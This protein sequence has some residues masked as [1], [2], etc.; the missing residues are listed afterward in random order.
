VAAAEGTP[1][2]SV[3]FHE[4]AVRATPAN[5]EYRRELAMAYHAARRADDAVVE[6]REIIRRDP[7]DGES[8][9]NLAALLVMSRSPQREEA[10]RMY[11]EARRLG[12]E[13]DEALEKV[14]FP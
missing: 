13:A 10:A 3:R 6:Y 11:R 4:S 9:F 8:Y 1:D 7:R 2:E 14:L 5:L 12:E